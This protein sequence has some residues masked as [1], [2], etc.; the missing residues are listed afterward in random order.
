MSC[1]VTIVMYHYVREL[2]KSRYPQIKGLSRDEF[3]GQLKYIMKNYNVISAVDLMNAIEANCE[4][5]LPKNPLLLTFDDAYID[6]YL[7]V[8]PILDRLNLTGCF[9]PPAKPILENRVLDVN[10][11]HFILA[12]ASQKNELVNL[13][14]DYSDKFREIYQLKNN[15]EYWEKCGVKSRF[16]PPEVMFVKNML[17]RELPEELRSVITDELFKR[18]VSDDEISFSKELYMDLEQI[19][20]LQRNGMYIG[21]HG[22]DHYWLNSISE[23][24]QIHEIDESIKFLKK[25]GSE[26][27]RWIMCYPYG[28]YNDS[29]LALLKSR[30][31][32]AGFTTQVGIANL[33]KNNPLLLPRMDTNDLPKSIVSN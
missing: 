5:E 11:I 14:F 4:H 2:E 16:D 24:K 1:D 29:L 21:S 20:C 23:D 13:I 30:N 10:K 25:V 33:I 22:F 15:Q 19:S 8:F 9:F 6:H 7:V 31:C 27:E 12:C 17:Q 18:Y 26:T 3:K 28:A 32:V